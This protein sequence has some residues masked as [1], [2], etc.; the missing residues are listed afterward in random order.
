M[1][2]KNYEKK[3]PSSIR[4]I[5]ADT[6]CKFF[7]TLPDE[8]DV[9]ELTDRLDAETETLGLPPYAGDLV[10]LESVYREVRAAEE[11]FP[12]TIPE[13]MINPSVH[14]LQLSWSN[15]VPL[16]FSAR[17]QQGK[18]PEPEGEVVIIWRDPQQQRVKVRAGY[19]E[20]LLVLKML[21]ENISRREA[22]ETGGVSISGIDNAFDQA[23]SRGILLAPPSRLRRDPESFDIPQ[24]ADE[25][26]LSARFFTLQWHITQAC[27]LHCRHCYDR[28]KRASM[29]LEQGMAILDQMHDF[30]QA[31]HVRGQV[32]FSGG[33]PL[34]YQHFWEL[35]EGAADRG[36]NIA[37]LGNPCSEEELERLLDIQ[38]P[39]F[40]QVSLEGLRDH[41]DAIRGAGHFDRVIAFLEVL[42]QLDIS[43]MVMLTLTGANMDQVMELAEFLQDKVDDFTFNRLSLV[44]EGANLKLPDR[45][46]F[47]EFLRRYHAAAADNPVMG[48]KDNLLNIVRRQESL[49]PFGGCT[50]YGCG[51]AFNF[52]SVLPDG[53]VHACRKFPSPIGNIFEHSLAAIYDSPEAARHRRGSSGCRGCLLRHVCGGCLAVTY[54]HGLDV[55]TGKDPFCFI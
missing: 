6:W 8:L 20:D 52:V 35:Y 10:Y 39:A 28:S 48:L 55:F 11:E 32:S 36:L 17:P 50:G 5:G 54:S 46:A 9:Q 16:L 7:D 31:R 34:L 12:E 33:N 45:Q 43:S 37:V 23:V 13:I 4:L 49:A 15:L 26:F 21:V 42:R 47:K 25:K 1:N 38:E 51:A 41:N 2:K 3:L 24:G 30:V 53:E 22:A 29:T 19:A 14:L 44:G 18:L 40:F 27:D